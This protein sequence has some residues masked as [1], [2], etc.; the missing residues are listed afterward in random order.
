LAKVMPRTAL[1][2]PCQ[3]EHLSILNEHG[4]LDTDLE[5]DLPHAQL[6][7]LHRAMLLARRFDERML[8]LQRQGRLGTFA[9]VRGQEAAQ[10]GAIAHLRHSDWMVPS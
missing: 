7:R 3:L 2:I 10:L 1:E 4:E 6:M 9:P 5:P 8:S